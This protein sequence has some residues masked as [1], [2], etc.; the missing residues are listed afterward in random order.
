MTW[1]EIY[2]RAIGQS[3][4][5]EALK[6]KDEAR[7]QISSLMVENGKPNPENNECPEECV[8]IFCR[9]Y[10]VTF[11]KKGNITGYDFSDVAK[12]L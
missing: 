1:D 3:F 7:F 10:S 4:G 9:K 11:D 12:Q 8:E 2:D 5:S 6:A